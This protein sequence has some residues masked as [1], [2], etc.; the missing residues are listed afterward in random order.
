LQCER[1]LCN[2][3]SQDPLLFNVTGSWARPALA[4]FN[5]AI[6]ETSPLPPAK[7]NRR[8]IFS[9]PHRKNVPTTKLKRITDSPVVD[10]N[11]LKNSCLELLDAT[12]S[13]TMMQTS[14]AD[15]E[16]KLLSVTATGKQI[17]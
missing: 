16:D 9:S 5:A 1:L 3:N 10:M 17:P 8:N 15:L 4:K 12:D 6:S 11:K 2:C 13:K 14:I 7:S